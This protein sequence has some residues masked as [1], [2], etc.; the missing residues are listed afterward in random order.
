LTEY[1]T[2]LV[3]GTAQNMGDE[4][5]QTPAC[6]L[7]LHEK[8]KL[9]KGKGNGHSSTGHKGQGGNKRYSSTLSLTSALDVGA[10]HHYA[11]F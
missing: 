1:I 8:K 2:F 9:D 6:M 10:I 11:I 5:S 3:T 7:H 4:S